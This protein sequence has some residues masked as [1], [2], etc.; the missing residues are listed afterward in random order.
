M[1]ISDILPQTALC[2]AVRGLFFKQ[3]GFLEKH[4]ICL[5]KQ[6]GKRILYIILSNHIDQLDS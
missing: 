5:T 4:T 6:L 2:S 3:K 1:I